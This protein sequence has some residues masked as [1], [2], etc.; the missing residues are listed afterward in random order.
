[1]TLGDE[2][3]TQAIGPL[4]LALLVG[5][6]PVASA[7]V[8]EPTALGSQADGSGAPT[9]TT[10]GT[11]A[12]FL[13][14]HPADYVIGVDDVLT[15][16]FW[17]DETMSGDFVVRPDGKISLPLL[18]DVQAAGLTPF[19]LCG[20]VTEAA[21]RFLSDPVV[22]IVVR[23]IKSRKVY[24]TGM[25]S[26]PGSYDLA[27][28]MT[29]LQLITTAGGLAEFADSKN[30]LVIRQEAGKNI[31]FKVNYDDLSK[32]KNLSQNIQLKPGDQV[33]VR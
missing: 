8:C 23:E 5:L 16:S 6:A 27:G 3:K 4:V 7:Q 19:Q 18:N 32:G 21:R 2:M 10:A 14:D 31:P 28:S 1:M 22:S 26:K 11:R 13:V 20:T 9:S 12:T 25:V 24:I 33:I 15:I 30:I 29:I 17:R